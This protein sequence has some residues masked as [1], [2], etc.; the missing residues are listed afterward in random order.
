MY[1]NE[2]ELAYKYDVSEKEI[3]SMCVN[4]HFN[5]VVYKNGLYYI[6]KKEINNNKVLTKRKDSY[7]GRNN[8]ASYE[9]MVN[10]YKENNILNN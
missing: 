6:P 2:R 7:N 1:I 8:K 3:N 4:K 10:Y 9:N 5:G